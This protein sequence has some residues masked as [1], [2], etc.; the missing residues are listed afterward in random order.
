MQ[1]NCIYC[2]FI[3]A[4]CSILSTMVFT[5][6]NTRVKLSCNFNFRL[7]KHINRFVFPFLN[8]QQLS[9]Q[10]YSEMKTTYSNFGAEKHLICCTK[11]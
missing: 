8:S 9:S 4:T 2:I 6:F 10:Y 5:L 3:V 1:I 7:K 11:Y